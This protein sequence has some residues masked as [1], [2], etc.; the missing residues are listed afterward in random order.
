MESSQIE[1][2]QRETDA[3]CD[4]QQVAAVSDYEAIC[5]ISIDDW[6]RDCADA[7]VR[8]H[9]ELCLLADIRA[10]ASINDGRLAQL[11]Y[12]SIG[13]YIVKNAIDYARRCIAADETGGVR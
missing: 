1:A 4:G 5:R 9:T 8:E 3:V 13:E 10:A 7:I 2:A 12:A 6:R 11:A